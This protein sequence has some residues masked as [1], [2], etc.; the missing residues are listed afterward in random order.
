MP[1]S[2][3][4]FPAELRAQ[5]SFVV[6]RYEN[7]PGQPK[8][9]KVPYVPRA[10]GFTKALSNDPSTWGHLGDAL[11]VVDLNEYDGIG[12]MLTEGLVFIDL[13]GCRDPDT[14]VIEEWA[15][16]IIDA[17]DSYTEL[18]PS[19]TGVHILAYGE[20]PASKGR[21]KAGVEMYS[22]GRYATMTGDRL[23]GTPGNIE[24]R[25]V[26]I[27]NLY[28]RVFGDDSAPAQASASVP[29]SLTDQEIVDKLS[30][31]RNRDKFLKLWSGDTGDYPSRSEADLAL[32]SLLAFYTQDYDQLDRLMR[33]SGLGGNRWGD[34]ADYRHRTINRAL[35]SLTTRYEPPIRGILPERAPAGSRPGLVSAGAAAAQ[36]EDLEE[37]E[38]SGE[39]ADDNQGDG[40]DHK[41]PE[42][43]ITDRPLRDISSDALHALVKANDPPQ[44]FRRS[45][46]LTRVLINEKK[47]PAIQSLTETHLRGRMDRVA[48]FLM[49]TKDGALRHKYPPVEVVRD[50][51]SLGD[52]SVPKLETVIPE[53][54]AI[55]EA[56]TLRPDGTVLSEPG[57]DAAT[58]LLYIPSFDLQVCDIPDQPS[59]EDVAAALQL[60]QE[61][62]GDFPYKDKASFANTIG[63]L[64]TPVIRSAINGH[65]PLAL[66]DAPRA[67][68]GKG[69]LSEVIF[70]IAQGREAPP[71]TAPKE[72]EEWRKTLTTVLDEG[73]TVVLID[74]VERPL[75]AAS[76]ASVLTA[77]TW[78]ARRLGSNSMIR[79]PQRAT[80]IATG[81]NIQL[82]GDIPRRCYWIRL[83][84]QV[85]RPW[86]RTGFRHDN[87]REW[88]LS[89]RS[90]LVAALLTLARSWYA[91]GRP[92]ANV[93]VV[94][95]FE[96]WSRTVGG[97]LQHVGVEGF[98]SNLDLLYDMTDEDATQWEAFLSAWLACI[99]EQPVTTTELCDA[100]SNDSTLLG[101]STQH[102]ELREA[103]PEELG[104][105]LDKDKKGTSGR[106]FR[107]KFG[108]A[109]AKRADTQYETVRLERAGSDDH[110]KTSKWR[111]KAKVG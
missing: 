100:L 66:I 35:N 108:R 79:I 89:H 62:I 57:Y 40:I 68:T 8:R 13:D 82:G 36:A 51:L 55:V 109:L 2:A 39:L 17:L 12:F 95:S 83:D 64:L 6:W 18:S 86:Q 7:K 19:G 65:V 41:L 92:R 75:E 15:Q 99:G 111:V 107:S 74:N 70:L 88:A 49:V 63:L 20:L 85:A 97:I 102:P 45:A 33:E 29:S 21:K 76:L 103:L 42:I 101:S 90:D 96:D 37:E 28:A 78:Q 44:L 54:D 73:A 52:W 84:A 43:I 87:L 60:V 26:E 25:P 4:S 5:R 3:N 27:S 67:G 16:E 93:P 9:A 48:N 80:W 22:S 1:F 24:Q 98:L 50:I 59:G 94:G 71:M 56:P 77:S 32:C 106:S 58:R 10:K 47:G 61:V 23:E 38:E 30:R 34:R 46:E 72:D 105:A 69:L 14:G 81:N 110:N 53:L 11:A 104:V 91:V 31:A